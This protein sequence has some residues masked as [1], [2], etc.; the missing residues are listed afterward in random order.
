MTRN[1]RQSPQDEHRQQQEDLRRRTD[2][3]TFTPPDPD[4]EKAR[5]PDADWETLRRQ[6]MRAL[7][8]IARP[9][10]RR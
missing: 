5:P 10:R 9:S 6:V 2:W 1:P 3:E 7:S 4:W 8:A